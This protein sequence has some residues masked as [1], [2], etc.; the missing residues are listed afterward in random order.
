MTKQIEAM[1]FEETGG[2]FG[3]KRVLPTFTLITLP[4]GRIGVE[5]DTQNGRLVGGG[6]AD[7]AAA[8]KAYKFQAEARTRM[9]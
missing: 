6:F 3:I 5:D 2:A 4:N 9:F 1:N 8:I 7:A